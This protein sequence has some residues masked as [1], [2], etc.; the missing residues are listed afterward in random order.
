[1][2]ILV[3]GGAG[4]IGSHVVDAYVE[5]GHKVWVLDNESSGKRTQVNRK[6]RYFKIDIRDT[7]KLKSIF[8]QN[9][10]DV[11]NHHAA[12]IDVRRSVENPLFD[13]QVN[14][15][16]ILNILNLCVQYQVKK[17]IF[18]SS[19]GTVYGECSRPAAEDFPEVPLSPYGVAKLASEKYIQAFASLHG[20]A[21]TIFRYANVYGPRQDPHG[22]AGVVAIFSQRLLKS[23]PTAIYGNGRQTRDFVYVKDV[24]R[25]NLLALKRGNNQILNI[26]TGK[27]TSVKS[28]YFLM[29]KILKIPLKAAYKPARK[30]ELF[31]SVLKASKAQKVLG[32]QPR[33]SLP[34]GLN[35]T[36]RY[37]NQ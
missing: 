31:R 15:L 27:E 12:Q 22:E 5:A 28:L 11:V 29:A 18:S 23:K 6:A 37:F 13:A 20:L 1:M 9:R 21:F 8:Q 36:I 34:Q 7:G 26:G 3:T 24:A 33:T 2:K 4:F 35:E 17:I 10:F 30:G 25:A 19:G 16:G 32:W 14:I